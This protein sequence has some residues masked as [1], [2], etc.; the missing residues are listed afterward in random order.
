LGFLPATAVETVLVCL[1]VV[2]S[3]IHYLPWL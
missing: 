1:G 2:F 3:L